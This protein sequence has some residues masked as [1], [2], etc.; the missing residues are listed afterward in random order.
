M[1]H[2]FS[3]LINPSAHAENTIQIFA[4]AH[5]TPQIVQTVEEMHTA[6][7]LVAEGVGVTLVPSSMQKTKKEGIVYLNLAKPEPILEMKMGYRKD[8]TTPVLSRFIE[9]VRSMKF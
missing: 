9:M 1:K 7:G 5:L 4:T 2:L 6:L 3:F 8:D